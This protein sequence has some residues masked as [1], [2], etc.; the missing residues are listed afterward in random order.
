MAREAMN[1]FVQRRLTWLDARAGELDARGEHHR[2]CESREELCAQIRQNLGED[3]PWFAENLL[4]LAAS[5]R[6]VGQIKAADQT[7]RRAIRCLEREGLEEEVKFWDPESKFPG[8]GH[9]RR[10]ELAQAL[11]TLGV[12]CCEQN[13]PDQAL[14]LLHRA[15]A[16]SQRILD[17]GDLRLATLHNNLGSAYHTLEDL[18]LARGH[19][20]EALRKLDLAGAALE[21]AYCLCDLAELLIDLDDPTALSHAGEALGLFRRLQASDPPALAQSLMRVAGLFSRQDGP[22]MAIELLEEAVDLL[23]DDPEQQHRLAQCLDLL[24]HLRMGHA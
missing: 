6:A 12:L 13:R 16:L 9:D 5:Y 24:G 21:R 1:R 4:R 22:E 20:L 15:L 17:H 7:L 3:H 18:E 19:Y 11:N 23:R 10:A 8:Q 14:R 2:S